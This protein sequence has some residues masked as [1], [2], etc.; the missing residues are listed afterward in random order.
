MLTVSFP[1]YVGTT[2]LSAS[3]APRPVGTATVNMMPSVS[4]RWE[5]MENLIFIVTVRLPTPMDHTTLDVSVNIKRQHIVPLDNTQRGPCFVLTTENAKKKTFGKDVIAILLASQDF[6]A[7]LDLRQHQK[8]PSPPRKFQ[9]QTQK[10]TPTTHRVL[11]LTLLGLTT[12]TMCR[13]APS[14]STEEPV[15]RE[16]RIMEFWK[17]LKLR[18]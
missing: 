2:V 8:L 3:I 16:L 14:V 1:V 13:A 12:Q 5:Q 9:P 7:N 18:I 11:P 15:T 6:R 10:P 17:I 4:R